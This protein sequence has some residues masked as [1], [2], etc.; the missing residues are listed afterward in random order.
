[1]RLLRQL[2]CGVV[3]IVMLYEVESKMGFWS[4]WIE[5]RGITQ[6]KHTHAI[7]DGVFLWGKKIKV[8][9]PSHYVE[10]LPV[11]LDVGD[12][13][14]GDLPVDS[15]RCHTSKGGYLRSPKPNSYRNVFWNYITQTEGGSAK[16]SG[17]MYELSPW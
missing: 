8:L 10:V 11:V 13:R 17:C 16:R 1:M 5:S 4:H 15:E 14:C 3:A 9:G 12:V 7:S 6:N 2:L